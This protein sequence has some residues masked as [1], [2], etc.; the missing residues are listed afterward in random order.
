MYTTT[1]TH[2]VLLASDVM[3]IRIVGKKSKELPVVDI[4]PVVGIAGIEIDGKICRLPNTGRTVW[5]RVSAVAAP[6]LTPAK[7]PA[8]AMTVLTPDKEVFPFGPADVGISMTACGGIS[9]LTTLLFGVVQAM[10][11][12]G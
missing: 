8:A 12:S 4:V 9:C 1:D 10:G 2:N 3:V 6:L 11:V 5:A 7:C